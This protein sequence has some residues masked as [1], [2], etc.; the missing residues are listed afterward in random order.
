MMFRQNAT[1][2]RSQTGSCS[3]SISRFLR[4]SFRSLRHIR[5]HR[6]QSSSLTKSDMPEAYS[7]LAPAN[8]GYFTNLLGSRIERVP[9]APPSGYRG[10]ADVGIYSTTSSASPISDAG[11]VTPRV[12]AVLRFTAN[13][14]RIG[15]CTGSSLGFVPLRILATYPADRRYISAKLGP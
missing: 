5:P 4:K 6:L 11:R 14:K 9:P 12:F 7:Q 1:K 8:V 3:G 15:C 13:S 10:I 2:H